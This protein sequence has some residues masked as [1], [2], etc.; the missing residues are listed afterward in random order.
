MLHSI[1]V[2]LGDLLSHTRMRL[3]SREDFEDNTDIRPKD[4][5][6]S[7]LTVDSHSWRDILSLYQASIFSAGQ[8]SGSS[9]RASLFNLF[10]FRASTPRI[11]VPSPQSPPFFSRSGM[12]LGQLAHVPASMM[13]L[14]LG[15]LLA[16]GNDD[17]GT[18]GVI[19][20]WSASPTPSP[21]IIPSPDDGSSEQDDIFAPSSDS[22]LHGPIND[23][24]VAK[25]DMVQMP[26][27]SCI[28]ASRGGL[29]V[30]GQSH[31]LHEYIGTVVDMTRKPNMDDLEEDGFLRYLT[32]DTPIGSMDNVLF[33]DQPMG[34]GSAVM[35]VPQLPAPNIHTQSTPWPSNMSSL[36]SHRGFSAFY[37]VKGTKSLNLELIWRPYESEQATPTLD[38]LAEVS[39]FRYFLANTN[40]VGKQ[41]KAQLVQL[42]KQLD[43]LIRPISTEEENQRMLKVTLSATTKSDL[44]T[45]NL[46]S[47]DCMDSNVLLT[48]AERRKLCGPF[49]QQDGHGG[50]QDASGCTVQPQTSGQRNVGRDPEDDYCEKGVNHTR[51][52]LTNS[53]N[54]LF[55]QKEDAVLNDD[56]SDVV[57][58]S[59]LQLSMESIAATPT[60]GSPPTLIINLTNADSFSPDGPHSQKTSGSEGSCLPLAGA[61]SGLATREE[62]SLQGYMTILAKRPSF[63]RHDCDTHL[64]Q[65]VLSEQ[66][67]GTT[68]SVGLDGLLRELAKLTT[69][70]P[71]VEAPPSH[72]HRYLA[73]IKLLQDRLLIRALHFDFLRIEL[74]EREWLNGADLVLDCDTALV[75]EF[76]FSLPFDSGSLKSKLSD[77]SWRYTHIAVIFKLYDSD[78]SGLLRPQDEEGQGNLSARVI[79]S[80]KKLHR[81][82]AVADTYA[83][84]RPQTVVQM[85]LAR[86]SEQAAAITRVLGEIAESRS[87]LGFWDN[88]LWLEEDEQE[89]FLTL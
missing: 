21:L 82:L 79:R 44:V 77:L 22:D 61:S 7:R 32:R 45:N 84:K 23:L 76:L 68:L 26:R 64:T 25:M 81:E 43:P 88:R 46:S 13:D 29:K 89:V 20:E 70:L 16:N 10:Y 41:S 6:Q 28:G 58:A 75:F 15:E 34:A 52:N 67:R 86:S 87:R 39:D 54:W 66:R 85:Y 65:L 18:S 62:Q 42:F 1:P 63:S 50:R 2:N 56:E 4:I 11:L 51:L 55:E 38:E 59:R 37:T 36:V 48:R 72:G 69:P 17:E 73:S 3:V 27:L 14:P 71:P 31:P 5:C 83:I 12:E 24:L 9:S 49:S 47:L 33:L 19:D 53:G 74:L 35:E 60:A 30:P 40:V 8:P 57:P 78:A 80:I